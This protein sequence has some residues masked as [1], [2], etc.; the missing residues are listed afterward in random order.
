MSRMLSCV[1][2]KCLTNVNQLGVILCLKRVMSNCEYVS[3]YLLLF[4][5]YIIIR[6]VQ[7]LI[8][9]YIY[10]SRLFEKGGNH[11]KRESHLNEKNHS[12][13][14]FIFMLIYVHIICIYKYTCTHTHKILPSICNH[15]PFKAMDFDN[16][17]Q[18]H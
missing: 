3:S 8:C 9:L 13:T 4:F 5:D 10:F 1:I 15:V 7:Y 6:D 2:L 16:C 11:E 18:P 12:G 14:R 17:D